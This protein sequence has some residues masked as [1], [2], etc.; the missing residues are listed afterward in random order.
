TLRSI[1]G[2]NVR[3]RIA[4]TA[5]QA[6]IIA[7]RDHVARAIVGSVLHARDAM[8]DGG[9]LRVETTD[10]DPIVARQLTG[11]GGDVPF[12]GLAISDSGP[13]GAFPAE[14]SDLGTRTGLG[15]ALV[16]STVQMAGGR[17]RLVSS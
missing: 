13:T 4:A 2:P 11:A 17:I 7:D 15:L 16:Y 6:T 3:V 9:D 14:G 8:P 10:V 1:S 5:P 12:V